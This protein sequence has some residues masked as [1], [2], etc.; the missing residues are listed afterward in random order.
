MSEGRCQIQ[1]CYL[2]LLVLY[3][4]RAEGSPSNPS[5]SILEHASTCSLRSVDA[6]E[7]KSIRW[8]VAGICATVDC[9]V[10]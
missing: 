7:Q 4:T 10:E 8:G 2:G 5:H 6:E 1:M 3:M 9:G